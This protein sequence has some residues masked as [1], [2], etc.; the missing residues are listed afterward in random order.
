METN[1]LPITVHYSDLSFK[2]ILNNEDEQIFWERYSNGGWEP[3]TLNFLL[4][5]IKVDWF[6]DI[7]SLIGPWRAI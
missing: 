2:V 3:E 6:I 4:K 1:T 5:N 7:G